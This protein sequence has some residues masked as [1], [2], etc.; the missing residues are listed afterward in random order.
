MPYDAATR[1]PL[2]IRWDRRVAPGSH[3]PR[4][5][6][7]LDIT[8]TVTRA[9]GVPTPD[10]EGVS[11]LGHAERH[12]FVLEAAATWGH[13]GNGQ[14]VARPGYCGFR[15]RRFLY[16]RYA[17]ATEELYDYRTDPWELTN[18]ASDERYAERVSSLRSRA[19]EGCSP[20][21]PGFTW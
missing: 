11:V 14:G 17:G 19:D 2:A 6:L 16:V 10:D 20:R 13:D 7:N 12:G 4:L 5:A 8:A 15:T 3:D 21:P 9:S 18:V 1:V